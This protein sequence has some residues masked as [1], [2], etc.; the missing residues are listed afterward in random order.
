MNSS[1]C[2][3]RVPRMA[4]KTTRIPEYNR[5]NLHTDAIPIGIRTVQENFKFFNLSLNKIDVIRTRLTLP[6]AIKGS[7]GA[8]TGGSWPRKKATN[9]VNIPTSDPASHPNS[10]AVRKRM[11]LIKGPVIS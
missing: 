3:K 6:A 10:V 1:G 8:R 7:M 4:G 9:G 11:A 2:G 5:T